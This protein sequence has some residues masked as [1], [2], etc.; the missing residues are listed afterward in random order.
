MYLILKRGKI[1]IIFVW[2]S[3]LLFVFVHWW[4]KPV[5]NMVCKY[6]A[7]IY[8]PFFRAQLSVWFGLEMTGLAK[9]F[10]DVASTILFL[11]VQKGPHLLQNGQLRR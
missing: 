9:T 5:N 2:F 11:V 8:I 3:N 1:I 6:T 7:Y 4:T 10:G